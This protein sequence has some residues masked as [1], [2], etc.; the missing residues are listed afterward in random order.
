MATV[1]DYHFWDFTDAKTISVAALQAKAR[2]GWKLFQ[3]NQGFGAAGGTA[4]Y[5]HA[6][7]GP[8]GEIMKAS[9]RTVFAARVAPEGNRLPLNMQVLLLEGATKAAL[10]V[11]AAHRQLAVEDLGAR[12][13]G[14]RR[15]WMIRPDAAGQFEKWV[16]TGSVPVQ[17]FQNL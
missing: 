16:P 5:E 3:V 7:I 6:L 14:E 17:M 10:A 2:T 12:W 11:E 1:L 15:R 13:N 8:A 4:N 9:T